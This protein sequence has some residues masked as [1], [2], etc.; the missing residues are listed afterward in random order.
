LLLR[1]HALSA[2]PTASP[3]RHWTPMS[4]ACMR[5]RHSKRRARGSA[6]R[7]GLITMKSKE[8]KFLHELGV[9]R[10][11]VHSAIQFFYAYL[12]LNDALADNQQ[13]HSLV[14]R[15]PLFWRT[16]LGALLSSY[17]IALGRI[18]DQDSQHNLDK[19][20][21]TARDHSI[22]F[23]SAA[24]KTRKRENSNNADEWIDEYMKDVYVPNDDDFRR[25][26]KHIRRYRKIYE[27]NYREIRH[28]VYAH[29]E[30]SKPEEIAALYSQTSIEEM[31]KMLVFLNKFYES[32][33]QLFH[34][35]RKPVLR[36]MRYSVNRIIRDEIPKWQSIHVQE[37]ITKETKEFIEILSSAQP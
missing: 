28:K 27:K 13:A 25:L 37:L 9:C 26:K 3:T 21:K 32:L 20:L 17:F 8:D 1:C 22:I 30:L 11:E 18:F 7:L 23:S 35:G 2:P 10:S 19:L 34:N 24:L 29:K 16:T 15:T 6:P 4:L 33:W 12:A 31:Q 36:P 5:L 14:N